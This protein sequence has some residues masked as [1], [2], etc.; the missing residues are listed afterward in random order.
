MKILIL[1]IILTGCGAKLST[2]SIKYIKD[3]RTGLCFA[4]LNFYKPSDWE[5]NSML[6]LGFTR[7]PCE[8]IDKKKKEII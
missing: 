2:T 5:F 8:K 6:G 4:V 7:V 1:L 3:S